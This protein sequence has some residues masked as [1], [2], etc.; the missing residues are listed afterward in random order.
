M[1]ALLL[2]ISI[3]LMYFSTLDLT[4]YQ[5][6]NTDL[7]CTMELAKKAGMLDTIDK[8][9]KGEALS[10]DERAKINESTEARKSM[11]QALK[12]VDEDKGPWSNV[13]FDEHGH[14]K[15]G[16]DLVYTCEKCSVNNS[17]VTPELP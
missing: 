16:I 15:N 8:L 2:I 1:T 3:G 10:D 11:E 14:L 9:K 12:N 4:K 6:K 17:I 5:N 7:N 13:L